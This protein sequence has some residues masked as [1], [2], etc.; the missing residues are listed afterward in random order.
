[1]QPPKREISLALPRTLIFTTALTCGL[2]TALAVQIQL[3]RMG[4]DVVSLWQNLFSPKALQ[5]RTAGPWWAIAGSAFIAGG[6][7]AAMLSRFPPPWRGFRMIRWILGGILVFA[8]AHVGH[9]AAQASGSGARAQVAASLTA[10]CVA[11]LMAMFGAF[12][13]LRR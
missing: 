10:F 12:F 7:V 11:V 5:L 9:G 8:L 1:M 3:S 4:L 6:V 13:T 2:L